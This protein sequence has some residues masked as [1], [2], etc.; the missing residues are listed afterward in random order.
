VLEGALP[1]GI[2]ASQRLDAGAKGV[3]QRLLGMGVR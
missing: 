2:N 3:G 1:G